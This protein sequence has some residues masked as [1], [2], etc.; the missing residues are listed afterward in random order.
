MPGV[1][2]GLSHVRLLDREGP[3]GAVLPAQ[4]SLPPSRT[5]GAPAPSP[6]PAAAGRLPGLDGLRGLAVAAVVAYHLDSSWLPG[7]FLGVDLF[8]VLSGFLITRN[9]VV[10]YIATGGIR[11][12]RFWLRRARRLLPALGAVL[13][14]ILAGSLLVWRDQLPSLGGGMPAVATYT[15]NWWLT[16]RHTSYFAAAG[17]PS[18][19]QHL[20][21]LA[22]EEQFYLGWPLVVVVVLRGRGSEP[23]RVGRLVAVCML[24]AGASTAVMAQLATAG[25]VPYGADGS[26]LYYGSDTHAMGLLAGAA[27]GAALAVHP[28]RWR[29]W[30]GDLVAL[31]ALAGLLVSTVEVDA[32]VPGLYRGDFL[33]VALLGCAVVGPVS[34]GVSRLGRV[35]DIAPLRWLGRRSYAVYLWHWP[36]AVVTRPGVDEHLTPWLLQPGRVAITLGLA[37]ASHRWVERPAAVAVRPA[38]VL[39]DG[40]ARTGAYAETPRARRTVAARPL[41]LTGGGLGIA[42]VTA[43]V[44]LALDPR[45]A[46][47]AVAASR[48]APASPSGPPPASV[49]GVAARPGPGCAAWARR[50]TVRGA[51]AAFGDSVLLG[52]AP[53]LARRFPGI[54]VD[55]V[56]GVQARPLLAEVRRRA[57]GRDPALTGTV[58]VHTGDNG[59]IAPDDLRDTLAALRSAGRVLVLTVRVDRPWQDPNDAT[60]RAA[61]RRD[62]HATL[63][64]WAHLSQGHP[65]WFYDGLHLTPTGATAYAEL[66]A[67][68]SRGEVPC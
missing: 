17:R 18:M 60:I 43:A 7:G 37:A 3:V 31:T 66:M 16:V 50:G 51:A 24:L 6:T 54:S 36:V 14:G 38:G 45:P 55:A 1:A 8:F 44:T 49:V 67:A 41:V 10:E 34:R 27:V 20:W 63:L 58:I 42:A 53:A 25:D 65:A 13:A 30:V 62:A 28:L 61:V 33:L 32:Y 9:L 68:A 40:L 21:S 23:A 39:A 19:L 12:G 52:A 11:L 2:S 48:L 47:G 46:T 22:I 57:A 64:D 15:T 5:P 26:R 29:W 56:V 4:R 35:L 59:V